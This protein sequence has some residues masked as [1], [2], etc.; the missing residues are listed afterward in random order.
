MQGDW[1]GSGCHTNYSTTSTRKDGGMDVIRHHLKLMA[2]HH[3]DHL[4]V[5]GE[6]NN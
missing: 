4:K 1:N 3:K 6:H 5:Y 2:D